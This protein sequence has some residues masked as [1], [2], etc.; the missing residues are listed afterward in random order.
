[1]P[2]IATKLANFLMLRLTHIKN[3]FLAV[4]R[5]NRNQLFHAARI[6]FW[7]I[8][9]LLNIAKAIGR[10]TQNIVFWVLRF[11][12]WR[13]VWAGNIFRAFARWSRNHLR[14]LILSINIIVKNSRA[15]GLSYSTNVRSSTTLGRPSVIVN[16]YFKYVFRV[17]RR[18]FPNS[19]LINQHQIVDMEL[20]SEITN[21]T[22]LL[23]HWYY[24]DVG[25]EIMQSIRECGQVFHSILITY[26]SVIHNPESIMTSIPSELRE[27]V[28]LVEVENRY[29]DCAPFLHVLKHPYISEAELFLKLHTKKSPHLPEGEGDL[30]RKGLVNDLLFAISSQGLNFIASSS[31]PVWACPKQWIARKEQWGF[32][33]LGVWEM[34]QELRIDFYPK[35]IFPVGNMY[36]FNRP[37][38]EILRTIEVPANQSNSENKLTDGT[39]AHALE[40]IP[41]QITLKNGKVLLI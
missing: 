40:R 23:L 12:Y 21:K 17:R 8:V 33:S 7:R 18:S 16:S 39:W 6:L 3:V 9:W 41:G 31:V 30:W 19:E 14:W 38:L 11:T 29:R 26:S 4:L 25:T 32:N 24:H 37:F 2:R 13:F 1:V 36:W 35:Y 27:I 5:W 10:W 20:N 28:A 22:C 34:T 15:R